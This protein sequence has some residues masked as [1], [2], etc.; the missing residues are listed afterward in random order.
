MPLPVREAQINRLPIREDVFRNLLNWI[1]DG[2]LRPGEKIVDKELAEHMGVSR[3]PVREALRRLEDKGLVESSANRW[4]RVSEIPSTEPEM[5]YPIIWTLEKL[6]LSISIGAMTGEDFTKM[7]QANNKMRAALENEDPVTASKADKKFHDV[8]IQRTKN[9]V[10]INILEDLKIRYRRLEVNYFEGLAYG[11]SSIKEHE[12]IISA[13]KNK[14]I[15]LAD[16]T[17]HSNWKRSLERF[18][19]IEKSKK[20]NVT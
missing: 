18:R 4:T 9:L 17:I 10:L 20:N 7:E 19:T 11:E 1:M 6:A 15:A 13:L 5:I 3:T 8:F 14:D 2:V 12:I 16:K